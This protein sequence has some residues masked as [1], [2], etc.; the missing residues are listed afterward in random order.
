MIVT[1]IPQHFDTVIWMKN[2][3]KPLFCS[4]E[5]KSTNERCNK[6]ADFIESHSDIFP[7]CSL[8][9]LNSIEELRNST[10]DGNLANIGFGMHPIFKKL[11][12]LA[13]WTDANWFSDNSIKVN[14]IEEF[15]KQA[16]VINE[17]GTVY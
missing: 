11:V 8:T 12:F 6:L 4:E 13:F 10:L 17:H 3:F 7:L 2:P 15:I 16:K 1:S 5:K 9:N 14:T